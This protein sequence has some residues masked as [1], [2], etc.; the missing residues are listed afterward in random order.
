MGQGYEG[1]KFEGVLIGSGWLTQTKGGRKYQKFIVNNPIELKKGDVIKAYLA[2]NKRNEHSP[3][4]YLF[5]DVNAPKAKA[6]PA[7]PDPQNPE[8][9]DADEDAGSDF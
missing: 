3:D 4:Y 5:H 1:S 9:S 7:E 8:R 2:K 6:R